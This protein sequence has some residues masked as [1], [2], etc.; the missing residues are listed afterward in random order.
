MDYTIQTIS[1]QIKESYKIILLFL[2]AGIAIQVSS[3]IPLEFFE[4]SLLIRVSIVVLPLA[5]SISSFVISRIYGGSKVFGKSYFLLGM[6]YFLFFIG[7]AIY[8]FYLDPY[9]DYTYSTF[10]QLFFIFST[11][12]ILSHIIINIRYFAE[13]LE[14]YQKILLILIPTITILLY[15]FLVNIS[16]PEDSSDFYYNLIFVVTS[17]LMLAF[18]IVG[19]TVF[20]Y[21]ALF[22]PWFLL[23]IGIFLGT[24][25]DIAYRYTSTFGHYDYGDASTSLWL[26][27]SM[28]M[29]YALYKHQ[30]SI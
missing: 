1:S 8:F 30:K 18:T 5:V 11:P 4:S 27:S 6:S 15:S 22:V 17:S 25:G 28:M 2:A 19:F 24:A 9:Q 14:D 23:L 10:V 3:E 26:A 13:K 16:P 29:I 12:F 7:E 21:T 20:R